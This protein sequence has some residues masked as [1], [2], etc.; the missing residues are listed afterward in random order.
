MGDKAHVAALRVA[1]ASPPCTNL[2]AGAG[3]D[4]SRKRRNRKGPD[5]ESLVD[6]RRRILDLLQ[7]QLRALSSLD[8]NDLGRNKS[9][10]WG[11]VRACVRELVC[12]CWACKGV[13]VVCVYVCAPACLS[14]CAGFGFVC[15]S[16][17]LCELCVRVMC[18][19]YVCK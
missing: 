15:V 2:P 7:F 5:G 1:G 8:L 19:S 18:A 13:R 17:C 16:V 3:L 12:V 10:F 6:L 9:D 4:G 11:S 14:A